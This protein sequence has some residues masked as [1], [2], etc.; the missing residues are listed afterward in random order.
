ME[1][2]SLSPVFKIGHRIGHAYLGFE[3]FNERVFLGNLLYFY[4][5]FNGD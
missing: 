1:G 2:I 3:H 4:A 5:R